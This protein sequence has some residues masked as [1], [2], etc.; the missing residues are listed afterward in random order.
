IRICVSATLAEAVKDF[1]GR[2][3][4]DLLLRGRAEALRA[5]EPLRAEQFNDAAT[6]S[7]L[8]AFAK[9]E[10]GDPSAIAA[11]AAHLGKQP[12]DQLTSF[13][14]KRLLNGVTGTQIAMD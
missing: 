14:L 7:Y 12:E 6:K 4:G 5:F 8:D 11:F 1:Y 13:H 3:I 10:A 2:P 9:L